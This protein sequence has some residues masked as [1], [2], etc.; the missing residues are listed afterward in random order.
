MRGTTQD[1]H[2]TL[3]QGTSVWV[4]LENGGQPIAFDKDTALYAMEPLYQ[5]YE[6][7]GDDGNSIR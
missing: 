3:L 7:Y 5:I 1:E 2:L 4:D 6:V